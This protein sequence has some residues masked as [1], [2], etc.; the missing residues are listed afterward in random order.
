MANFF[1]HH[2]HHGSVW[3]FMGNI[4]PIEYPVVDRIAEFFLAVMA[5]AISRMKSHG[6][7][8]GMLYTNPNPNFLIAPKSAIER[9]TTKY[10]L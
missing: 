5:Y 8:L 1:S 9:D 10:S 3:V 6:H 2:L 7:L 4:H